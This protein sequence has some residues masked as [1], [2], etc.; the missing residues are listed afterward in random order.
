MANSLRILA[1]SDLHGAGFQEAAAAIDTHRPDW[2][3]LCGDLLPDFERIA[4]AGNRLEAQ[5]EFW[6]LHRS[7]FLRPYAV[8]TLVRGNHELEGFADPNLF[9]NVGAYPGTNTPKIHAVGPWLDAALFSDQACL[10]RVEYSVDRGCAYRQAVPDTA[11]AASSFSNLSGLRITGRFVRIS[12]INNS[13]AANA[14]VE[15][16]VYIRST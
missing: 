5:R 11:V 2:I 15:F 8:T 12:L 16:G 14:N 10:I 13:G 9:N 1:F 3:V 6:R 4:G 7:T